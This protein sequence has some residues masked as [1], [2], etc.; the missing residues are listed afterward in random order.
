MTGQPTATDGDLLRLATVLSVAARIEP[1]LIRA[2]RLEV[3]PGLDV[4]CESELWFSDL[5]SSRSR[6]A[7]SLRPDLLPGLRDE[8]AGMLAAAQP[9]DPLRRLGDVI[10]DAHADLPPALRIEEEVNWL[11]VESVPGHADAIDETLESALRALVEENR[12]GVV[13]WYASAHERLPLQ[14]RA[15]TSGWLLATLTAAH[16]PDMI[17][18]DTPAPARLVAA[19]VARIS[20]GLGDA[21][22][23]L[24][25]EGPDLLIMGGPGEAGRV[26]ILVP[27]TDPRLVEVIA[28]GP[29]QTL[30]VG[31]GTTVRL[32]AGGGP[33]RLRT[34]RGTVYD[35]TGAA[36]FTLV[37]RL[38]GRLEPGD[39]QVVDRA[40]PVAQILDQMRSVAQARTAGGLTAPHRFYVDLP[41][42]AYERIGPHL[43]V[44]EDELASGYRELASERRWGLPAEPVVR[45]MADPEVVDRPF[46]LRLELPPRPRSDDTRDGPRDPRGALVRPYVRPRGAEPDAGG[47]VESGA[48]VRPYVNPADDDQ[49]DPTG[50]GAPH[51]AEPDPAQF[52]PVEPDS[53]GP[54]GTDGGRGAGG[55]EREW[56]EEPDRIGGS[57]LAAG[58]HPAD[59]TEVVAQFERLLAGELGRGYP[60]RFRGTID[61]S[62]ILEKL[63]WEATE[64]RSIVGGDAL[65]VALPNHYTVTVSA[66]DH[67]RLASH[68]RLLQR[69]FA[70]CVHAFARKRGW[71]IAGHDVTVEIVAGLLSE[72]SFTIDC[73]IRAASQPS[74]NQDTAELPFVP[75]RRPTPAP[76]D[77]ITQELPPIRTP[78]TA[79]LTGPQL[80]SRSGTTYTIPFGRSILGKG[81]EADIW[82]PDPWLDDVH[83]RVNRDTL[84][85]RLTRL[86]RANGILVNGRSIDTVTLSDGDTLEL[87]SS[88]LT[89]R[90]GRESPEQAGFG[91][92]RPA[93]AQTA[94]A[95]R[96]HGASGAG[97]DQRLGAPPMRP[98]FRRRALRRG[99]KADEVDS[100]LER[101]SQ[102][103]LGAVRPGAEVTSQQVHEIVFRVRFGG[104]DEW[105]VDLYL[106]RLETWLAR[107]EAGSR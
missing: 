35:I 25:W 48:L 5:V 98:S 33:V 14:A 87:G 7:V 63:L 79:R 83:G 45:F 74:W 26:R 18:L 67:D 68:I 30:L 91:A 41:P 12:T 82:L 95:G 23:G 105:Q 24:S 103:V 22:L 97:E 90:A 59:I 85:V 51:P 56:A 39:Y 8:L 52:G 84:S 70:S 102:T 100:F 61:P 93:F 31:A 76:D 43:D 38:A 77:E 19:D 92:P 37:H 81:S 36:Q 16:H 64:E 80:V 96:P 15:T 53:L 54:A 62:R 106:D 49:P 104:Y 55:P 107:W 94:G 58:A 11:A 47:P 46:R 10:A 57:G 1:D 72:L 89:F 21:Q 71:G 75:G 86:S 32:P 101:V 99:Y 13:D 28:P 42:E 73:A 88:T 34:A 50:P 69:L 4:G 20:A 9:D 6:E 66:V 29:T 78:E 65:L 44:L 17:R 27:D 60:R 40:L 2:V 3:L